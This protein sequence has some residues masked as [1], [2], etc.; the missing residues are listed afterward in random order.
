[1]RA[2]AWLAAFTMQAVSLAWVG[3]FFLFGPGFVRSPT[4][5]QIRELV[6]HGQIKV[7]MAA[8]GAL[9]GQCIL[10]LFVTLDEVSPHVL[11]AVI[12]T[13]D[14]RFFEHFGIDLKGVA[15]AL[16]ANLLGRTRQGGS[17]I[18]QQLVKNVLFEES[19]NALSRKLLEIPIAMRFEMALSK[20]E[21]LAA[22]LNQVYFAGGVIGIEAAARH[23]YAKRAKDLNAYEAAVLVG[24]LKSPRDYSPTRNPDAAHARAKAVLNQEIVTGAMTAK[25]IDRALRVRA[26]PGAEALYEVS[27]QYFRDWAIRAAKDEIKR[28]GSFRL[29]VTLDAWRQAEMVYAADQA[30]RLGQAR[31]ASQIAALDMSPTGEV[32]AMLG[33]SDYGETQFNRATQARRSPGS[34]AK[35]ALYAEACRQGWKAESEILDAPLVRGW[36]TNHDGEYWG[37]VSLYESMVWSRN[38]SAAR[39][40]QAVG[41]DKV[42]ATA[43]NL[44][45][46]GDLPVG[47]GFSLGAFSASLLDM[48]AAYAAVANGG[49]RASPH[50]VLGAIAPYGEIAHWRSR[51]PQQRVLSARC[52]GVLQTMLRGVVREGTGKAANFHPAVHGKTGTSNDY[53]DAWFVGFFNDTVVGLWVGNDGPA[54]TARVGGAGLPAMAFRAYG[55]GVVALR[56]PKAPTRVATR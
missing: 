47:R 8:D 23:F 3:A 7:A 24:M 27:C 19:E 10:P 16:A 14:R 53:R 45:I 36:P 22:Y 9:A 35:L 12:A 49:N 31:N 46:S 44:G 42:V 33:G 21:I 48:T 2:L 1:M 15:R 43:R 28:N 18:T 56:G 6:S 11:N 50:G 41:A 26:R 51:Q 29:V 34:L 37:R 20:K 38:G 52:A 5:H 32:R 17:T 55:E 40:E 30:V 54:P 25:E 13:E 39:L 4:A